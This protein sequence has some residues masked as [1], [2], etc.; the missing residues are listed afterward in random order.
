MRK[1][2][3]MEDQACSRVENFKRVEGRSEK[4]IVKEL[5]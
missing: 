3:S 5:Q 1:F 2:R 4:I